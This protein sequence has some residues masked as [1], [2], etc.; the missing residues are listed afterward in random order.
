MRPKGLGS[1]GIRRACRFCHYALMTFAVIYFAAV[2][3][4]AIG[5]L[6]L[7]GADKDPLAGVF[8]MPFGLPWNLALD[9]FPEGIR[10]MA[11]ALAPAVNLLVL[12]AI[13]LRHRSSSK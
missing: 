7:F 9:P 11:A 2:T 1:A 6:G 5:T 8:L 4:F 3:I 10:P 12:W 13:C